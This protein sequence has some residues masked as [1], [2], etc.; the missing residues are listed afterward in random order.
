[1]KKLA[2][3]LTVMLLQLQVASFAAYNKQP[4]KKT[5][6]TKNVSNTVKAKDGYKQDG[7]DY[8]LKYNINDL[9]AAPW[10]NNGKRTYHSE[11]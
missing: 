11:K 10:L 4:A 9:E 3:I 2:L 8:L 1:M 6:A 7:S 5:N